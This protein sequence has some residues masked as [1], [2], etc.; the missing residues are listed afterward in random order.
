MEGTKKFRSIKWLLLQ[1]TLIPIVAVSLVIGCIAIFSMEAGMEDEALSSL[2]NTCEAVR[3]G[4]M[5]F[6]DEPYSLNQDGDMVKGDLNITKDEELID[7]WSGTSDVDV[8]LFYGDTREATSLCDVDTGERI[9]GTQ[10]S[11]EVVKQVLEGGQEIALKGITVNKQS[12]YAYYVPLHNPDGSTV[13]MVSAGMPSKDVDS[14]IKQRAY[15]IAGI[16]IAI[17][18]AVCVVC[19][20][21]VTRVVKFMGLAKEAVRELGEGNLTFRIDPAVLQ[22]RD[23]LGEIAREVHGLGNRLREIVGDIQKSAELVL[24]SGDELVHVTSNT[25]H[26]ANDISAAVEDISKGAVSQAEEI[27]TATGNVN[28]MGRLIED[29]VD[30]IGRLDETSKVMQQSEHASSEI[31]EQLFESNDKTVEAIHKISANISATDESVK[32]IED[33]VSLISNL[34]SQTNLLSLNASIEAARA[35]EA[36][37]GFAVVATEIQQLAEQSDNAAKQISEIIEVLAQNS[38]NSLNKMDEVNER[39]QDQQTKFQ[40]TKEQ[41]QGVSEGIDASRDGT[42]KI[43]GQAQEC[44]VAR[45]SVIDVI[46]SLSAISQENAASA[47]ETSASMQEL[48]DSMSVLV[49]SAGKLKELAESLQQDVAYFKM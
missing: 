35:G 10:A 22:R 44:N 21:I 46:Q 37:R 26:N 4:Y 27:E 7:S 29:I 1:L 13:G 45:T 39:L 31:M 33:A 43:N 38:R 19:M 20:V 47:Q 8:T 15:T 40:E 16:S 36:G 30:N 18:L 3:A 49:E 11:E 32:Q 12:Y 17:L 9:V 24:S 34:A 14:Y 42:D 25:S 41:F 6:N 28:D 5:A 23:E 48:N 2:Q